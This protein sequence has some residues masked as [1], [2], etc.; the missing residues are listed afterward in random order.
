MSGSENFS[1]SNQSLGSSTRS[2]GS[3]LGSQ[4]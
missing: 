1:P 2:K 4:P 3:G